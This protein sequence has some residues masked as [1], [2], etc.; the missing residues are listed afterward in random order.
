MPIEH[1]ILTFAVTRGGWVRPRAEMG[2]DGYFISLHVY[3]LWSSAIVNHRSQAGSKFFSIKVILLFSYSSNLC[4]RSLVKQNH[5]LEFSRYITSFKRFAP[6]MAGGAG[7]AERVLLG[8][9]LSYPSLTKSIK[10][11]EMKTNLASWRWA[12][13]RGPAAR[14]ASPS[15]TVHWQR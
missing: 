13:R 5:I 10:A 14:G 11:A 2:S 7:R 12:E 6:W 9:D 3:Y 15:V 4:W 1:L 8:V